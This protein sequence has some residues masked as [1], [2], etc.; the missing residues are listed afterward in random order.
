MVNP[1][2]QVGLQ[3]GP[4]HKVT[5]SCWG[6]SQGS[7]D[8]E[9]SSSSDGLGGVDFYDGSF[10]GDTWVVPLGWTID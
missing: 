2:P 10:K 3:G 7:S 6:R 8:Y 5:Q 1:Y 4:C 9:L